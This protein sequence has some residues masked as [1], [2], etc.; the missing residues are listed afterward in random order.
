MRVL[1]VIPARG[2]SKGVPRKN[3]RPLLGRPLIAYSIDAARKSKAVDRVV[4]STEDTEIADISRALG[5]EVL[6]RPA[7]LAGDET[8]TRDVLWHVVETLSSQG[9]R[10]DAVLTLQPTS[11]MRTTRHID[12]AIALFESRDDADSLVSCMEVPHV[13]SP[14]SV[15]RKDS[16][17]YLQPFLTEPQRYRRQEKETV[18]AR[19]G[20]AIYIT[21]TARLADYVFGGRLIA[22]M[23][24]ID[25]SVDIDTLDDF[26]AAERLMRASE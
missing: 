14:L 23:M 7:Q 20:A 9:Y 17:G 26:A 8:P 16:S 22:Y 1:A 15:M 13:F 18:Y 5:A 12:E 21:R 6:M 19:N 3:I 2:G 25:Q 24:N 11:P 4:V 10:P